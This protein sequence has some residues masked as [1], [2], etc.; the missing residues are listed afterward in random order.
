MP[1]VEGR[2]REHRHRL[3]Q[4]SAAL[5]EFVRTKVS[6][7]TLV[8]LEGAGWDVPRGCTRR[9]AAMGPHQYSYAEGSLNRAGET[10]AEFAPHE[11]NHRCADEPN[12]TIYPCWLLLHCAHPAPTLW[13]GGVACAHA[14]PQSHAEE[15]NDLIGHDTLRRQ[16]RNGDVEKAADEC[17][18]KNAA[19][20][21]TPRLSYA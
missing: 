7:S 6:V 2:G 12:A 14:T 11:K 13:R 19:L 15:F 16:L 5:Y 4:V 1:N 10:A 18:K 20:E 8:R 21:P 9:A 17:G 3:A